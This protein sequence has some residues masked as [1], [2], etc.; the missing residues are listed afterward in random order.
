VLPILGIGIRGLG[1]LYAKVLG[2]PPDDLPWDVYLLFPGG[3]LCER[4]AAKPRY[5]MHQVFYPSD[6][7]LDAR[8]LRV[9]VEKLLRF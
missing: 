3:V 7:H 9:E 2:L 4:E 5:W 8:K 1:K 6:N